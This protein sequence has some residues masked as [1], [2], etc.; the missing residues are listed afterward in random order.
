MRKVWGVC[1]CGKWGVVPE[2]FH[3]LR[4]DIM[5]PCGEQMYL[6][7][8]DPKLAAYPDKDNVDGQITLRKARERP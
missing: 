3:E 7:R 1:K 6:D 4:H 2:N 8:Q 5:C